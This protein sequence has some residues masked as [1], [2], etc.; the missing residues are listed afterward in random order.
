MPGTGIESVSSR[1]GRLP[2]CV[3]GMSR[4]GTSLTTRILNLLGVQLGAAEDLM[5]PIPGDNPTGFWEHEEIK[6][7]N[8]QI[9]LTLG[10]APIGEAWRYPPP[11]SAGWER[12]PLLAHHNSAARLLLRRSFGG[13]PLWGWKDPRNCLTLPFWQR[14]VP[15]MCYV[16]CVRDPLDVA[17]SLA[18]RNGVPHEEALRLWLL[19]TSRALIHTSGRPRVLVS[20]EGYFPSWQRQVMYLAGFLG[21]PALSDTQR[22]VI[23]AHFDERLWH[24]RGAKQEAVAASLP[25]EVSELQTLLAALCGPGGKPDVEAELDASARRVAGLLDEI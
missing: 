10:D 9:L 13:A 1:P 22:A 4:S 16:I 25:P 19:Y 11:L 20:Y 24:H 21:T 6:D 5:N 2:I 8:E 23:A 14:L 12:S 17:A 15:K 3:L 18:E 7:L